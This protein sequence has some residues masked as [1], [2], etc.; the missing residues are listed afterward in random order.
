LRFISIKHRQAREGGGHHWLRTSHAD[1][2]PLKNRLWA[3]RI[4]PIERTDSGGT[5]QMGI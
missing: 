1:P 5:A 2:F 4:K 3:A